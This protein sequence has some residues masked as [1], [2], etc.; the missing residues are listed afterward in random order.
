MC[1]IAGILVTKSGMKRTVF[2]FASVCSASRAEEHVVSEE[3]EEDG[4]TNHRI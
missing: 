3:T 2:I 4:V 1:F